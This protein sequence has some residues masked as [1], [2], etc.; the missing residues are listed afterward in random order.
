MKLIQR[1]SRFI[2]GVSVNKTGQTGVILTTSSFISFLLFQA[3]WMLGLVRNAYIGLISYMLFPMLFIIGLILI[4]IGWRLYRKEKSKSTRELLEE[5]FDESDIKGGMF[6]SNIV[7]TIA[8]LTF[9][10]IVFLGILS[11]QMLH[12]MDSPVFC[13]TACH[14]VMNPEWTTYQKSPHARVPCVDCHVGEGFEALFDSKLNGLRQ[15]FLASLK[16]YNKPIPTPVHQLRPARETCEKCH[17]PDK[18]YGTR[19]KNVVKYGNDEK[20]TPLYTTLSL[21]VD[22]GKSGLKSGIHWHIAAENE[23]KYVSA[24]DRREEMKWVEVKQPDGTFKRFTHLKADEDEAQYEDIESRILDC[25]DCHNRATHIYMDAETAV[26]DLLE[27]DVIDK[28]LPYIKREGVAAVITS[29]VDEAAA[30][31]SIE[32]HLKRFYDRNYMQESIRYA[33]SIDRAVVEMQKIYRHNVH[34]YMNVDWGAYSSHLGHKKGSGCFR[35]HDGSLRDENGASI[36]NDC[37]LCHSFLSYE[38][39]Q[40]YKYLLEFDP[41]APEALMQRYLRDE[42]LRKK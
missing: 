22:T 15:I 33:A 36:S 39:D 28:S 17:W 21:K 29:Y 14:T 31:Y 24:D 8:V 26:D 27:S 13:G 11:T 16:I 9:A 5:S 23:V 30:L 42:F 7:M 3:A 4:P 34:K 35:C 20:S 41:D 18:F 19:I 10:N 6:G 1:Y 40:P 38:S 25:V 37:T 32:N 12:F 2:K